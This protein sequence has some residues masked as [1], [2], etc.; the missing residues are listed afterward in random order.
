MVFAR[1]MK[2]TWREETIFGSAVWFRVHQLMMTLTFGLTLLGFILI[3]ADKGF[4]AYT[5]EFI[6]SN[7]HPVLGFICLLL[8]LIQPVMA[9]LRP[10]P[11]HDKRWIFNWAHFLVA[12]VA[13]ILGK[14][15]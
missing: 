13:F 1:Y 6:A 15:S 2:E 7:P 11:N 9:I 3:S 10:S 5:P 12:N 8:A 14:H 4:L